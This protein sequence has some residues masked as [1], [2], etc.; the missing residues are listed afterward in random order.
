VSHGE[1]VLLADSPEDFAAWVVR[2]AGDPG[3][4]ARVCA[5]ARRLVEE[6]LDWDVQARALLQTHE[7]VV[8]G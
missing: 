3:L 2:L 7:E 6:R 4:R 1:H 8:R 5:A